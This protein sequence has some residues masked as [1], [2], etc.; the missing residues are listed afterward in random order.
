MAVIGK[1]RERSWML[2][3]FLAIALFIFIIQSALETPSNIFSGG[4]KDSVGKID[5]NNVSAAEFS[6]KITA[7]EEGLRLINPNIQINDELRS[8]INDEV[9]YNVAKEALLDKHLKQLGIDV[10]TNEIGELMWGENAHPLARNFWQQVGAINAQTGQIDEAKARDFIKNIDKSD[11][12]GENK[13]RPTIEQIEKLIAEETIK[14]KYTDLVSKS[15]YMPSFFTK[16]IVN[17][18]REAVASVLSVPFTSLEDEKYKIS[19]ADITK[20]IKNNPAKFKQEATRTMDIVAFN[21]LPTV[22]DSLERKEKIQKLRAEYLTIT[23]KT[24]DTAFIERNAIQGDQITF[25]SKKD[26]ANSGRDVENLF[27]LP[28]GTLTDIY[29]ANGSYVFTKIID[30]KNAPDSVRAAHILLSLGNKTDDEI[31]AANKKADSIIA[32]AASGKARF[33]DL[34]NQNS[35]DDNSKIK[36]GDLGYFTKNMMV[37]EFNDQV[38]FKG[39]VPGQIA[40]VESQFGLHIILLLDTR[41]TQLLT[42]FADFVEPIRPSKNTDKDAYNLAT[43][44]FQKNDTPDKF[45]K[46]SKNEQTY[47]NVLVSSNDNNIQNI[48]AAREVVRWAFEEKEINGIKFFDLTDK[49]VVAKLNKITDKG[50]AQADDVREEVTQILIKEKK[51]A[52]IAAQ[53][54]KAKSGKT[55]LNSIASNIKDAV[56]DDSIRVTFTSGYTKFGNEPKLSGAIFGT[57]EN[58][59]SKVIKGNEGVYI[60]QPSS[61][62]KESPNLQNQELGAYQ[63]QMQ[64]MAS[65]RINY[66]EIIKSIIDKADI[67]D[68]RYSYF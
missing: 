6:N 4:K 28:V 44:F 63:K 26:V 8:Q 14:T 5:G 43:A 53:L 60:V 67:S 22:E 54:E 41:N 64:K 24:K 45:T 66:Q 12:N 49:F 31:A 34:A 38:F 68:K 7:Y 20:Y 27:S 25:Y 55:N 59:I 19:D 32:L 47:K 62:Q 10:T 39:M 46:A 35:I 37:K 21:I 40:K 36:G 9:W 17:S 57:K 1:I 48:G 33:G 16:E 52:T 3:T 13:L 29:I 2:F 15:Y 61:I 30:R 51:A 50:L 42:K 58:T 11:P 65:S 18:S 23:D 56:I